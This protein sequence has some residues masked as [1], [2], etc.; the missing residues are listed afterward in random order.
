MLYSMLDNLNERVQGQFNPLLKGVQV[1]DRNQTSFH[2]PLM[3]GRVFCRLTNVVRWYV[4]LAKNTNV[5]VQILV[6]HLGIWVK[7]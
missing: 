4:V 1:T 2:V 3:V 7:P 6:R 5:K